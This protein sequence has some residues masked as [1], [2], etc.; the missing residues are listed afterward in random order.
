MVV[1]L[2]AREKPPA[3]AQEAKPSRLTLEIDRM[4]NEGG[5]ATAQH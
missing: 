2:R 4:S 5:A 3:P 1:T